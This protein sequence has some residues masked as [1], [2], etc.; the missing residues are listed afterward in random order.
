[1]EA[2]VETS[3]GGQ[4]GVV[5]MGVAKKLEGNSAHPGQPGRSVRAR[6]GGDPGHVSPRSHH[7]AAEAQRHAGR[8]RVHDDH[9]GSGDRGARVEA[10]RARRR[11][12]SESAGVRHRPAAAAIVSVLIDTFAGEIRRARRPS[13]R[14]VQRRR[15]APGERDELRS[16]SSCRPS[17][18]KNARF[19]I[20]V[21]RRFPRH[22]EFA[23]GAEHAATGRCGSG[24]PGVRGT[25]VQVESRMTTTGASAD[26]WVPV[27]PGTEGVLALGLAHVILEHKL[28]P[29]T[30]RTRQR[31]NRRLGGRPCRL[32]AC[33]GRADHR[34][35]GGAHRA[36]RARARGAE[37]VGR[38]RRRRAARAHQC[39]VHGARGQRAQ[40]IARSGRTARRAAFHAADSDG[41][42][43]E[44]TPADAGQVCRRSRLG[45]S[46]AGRVARR[47]RESGVRGAEGLEGSR[48]VRKGAVHRELRELRRRNERARRSRSSRIL[49]PRVVVGR[50]ARIR[51]DRRGRQRGGAGDEAAVPDA[52]HARRAA[53]RGEEAEEAA[54]AAVGDLRGDAQGRVRWSR[55]RRVGDRAETGRMVG[56]HQVRECTGSTVRRCSAANRTIPKSNC[57]DGR[58]ATPSRSS[59]A[60]RTSIRSISCRTRRIA[61]LDGSLAHLPWLQ[62]MPD[63][64]TSAMWS[65]WVEINPQTAARLDIAQGDIV[66]IASPHGIAAR[67]GVHLSGHRARHR[68]DAGRPGALRRSPAT[69]AAAARTRSRSSRR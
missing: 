20:S 12:Q 10:R 3:R 38:D 42:P 32:H 4:Q 51:L 30:Q 58:R 34:R 19:V 36:S 45:Q 47:Q 11:R 55:R 39:A 18:C 26:E 8:R 48:G 44:R 57:L 5:R 68:R 17:I 40:R 7:A 56:G 15:A 54:R 35:R 14:A 67:A 16:A 63:P 64:M 65:S 31:A 2:D 60:M 22:V 1:M 9:V 53:R 66:E 43:V 29:A 21:R 49:V 69:R 59:T 52:R 41:R 61:F 37:P 33:E 13:L 28:R 23:G 62:E 24:R 27:K 25:F 50:A 6:S 46:A